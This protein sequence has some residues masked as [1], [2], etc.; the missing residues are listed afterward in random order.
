MNR[1]NY[2]PYEYIMLKVEQNDSSL[3]KLTL[4]NSNWASDFNRLGRAIATNSNISLLEVYLDALFVTGTGFY[5][6][7]KQNAS[8]KIF[9]IKSDRDRPPDLSGVGSEIL[10]AY[11]ENGNLIFD[12]LL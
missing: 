4:S 7:L 12:L 11:Q 6:G 2:N 1:L 5:D 8:I 9:V 3:I 10:Q